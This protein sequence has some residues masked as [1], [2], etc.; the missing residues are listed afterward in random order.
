[1]D[2]EARKK[3]IQREIN[4]LNKRIQVLV[5]E[6]GRIDLGL[7]PIDHHHDPDFI[8][9]FLR[10]KDERVPRTAKAGVI[11][12]DVLRSRLRGDR[13]T[14]ERNRRKDSGATG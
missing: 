2:R 7:P 5:R 3:E 8:P 9:E 4:S 12:L 11:R 13:E 1:M 14:Q 6:W 10:R